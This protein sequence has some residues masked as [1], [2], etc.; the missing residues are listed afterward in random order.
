MSFRFLAIEKQLLLARLNTNLVCVHFCDFDRWWRANE[1]VLSV[2]VSWFLVTFEAGKWMWVFLGFSSFILWIKILCELKMHRYA[3]NKTLH[4][5]NHF[6]NQIIDSICWILLVNVQYSE[7]KHRS[8]TQFWRERERQWMNEWVSENELRVFHQCMRTRVF[9][10]F[11]T[12]AIFT[13]QISM[14][15]LTTSVAKNSHSDWS[16]PTEMNTLNR[17]KIWIK[18]N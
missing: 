10:S 18:L 1:C 4:H 5:H 2:C 15:D 13:Y 3:I 7:H 16:L 14:F 8:H 9:V 12:I 17:G 11:T 6:Y